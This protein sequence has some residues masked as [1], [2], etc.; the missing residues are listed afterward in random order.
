M[1]TL[2]P[3]TLRTTPGPDDRPLPSDPLL[4]LDVARRDLHSL[5]DETWADDAPDVDVLPE[6][7]APP[8]GSIDVD[9][10][11]DD[12]G[13]ELEAVVTQEAP[14]PPRVADPVVVSWRSTVYVDGEPVPAQ[15]DPGASTTVWTRP[16]GAGTAR[17][18]L[19]IAGVVVEAEVELADGRSSVRLGRDVLAGRFWIEV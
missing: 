10:I 3:G 13:T 4:D 5:V 14:L 16:G 7:V 1:R 12:D 2:H 18:R 19:R 8:I 11:A 9:G 15:A 6:P 17:A